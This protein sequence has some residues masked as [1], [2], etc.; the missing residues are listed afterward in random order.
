LILVYL[1]FR[2]LG[3][4]D[5]HRSAV[6]LRGQSPAPAAVPHIWS[7]GDAPGETVRPIY[8]GGQPIARTG[9]TINLGPALSTPP[10]ALLAWLF[11]AKNLIVPSC[12][13]EPPPAAVP[14]DPDSK[15]PVRD[16]LPGFYG[17]PWTGELGGNLVALLHVYAPRSPARPA[18][19]TILQIYRHYDGQ[20][21]VPD[22]SADA[23]VRIYRGRAAVLY[24]VFA[25]SPVRCIDLVVPVGQ[26]AG[27]GYLYY[28]RYQH[29]FEATARFA[30]QK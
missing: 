4:G 12:L 20:Q 15:L 10:R 18:D 26:A 28:R 3:G 17:A 24:R 19:D 16:D 27:T 22:V 9:T 21:T 1:A 5:V 23:P 14:G 7:G 30:V 25:G 13:T 6:F 2:V 8:F 29:Y 11:G